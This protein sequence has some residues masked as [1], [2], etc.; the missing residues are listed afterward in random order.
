MGTIEQAEQGLRD[1]A[2]NNARRDALIST[3]RQAGVSK[4]RIHI[5]TGIAR[6]TIDRI[7][8]APMTAT[9]SYG[10]FI[11]HCA[12]SGASANIDSYVATALGEYASDYDVEA[13]VNGFRDGINAEL[14]DTGVSL[15]GDEFY[16]PYPKRDTDIAAAIERVDFW[17]IAAKHDKSA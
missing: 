4:N 6:T 10:S 2:A 7:L 12:D 3:A 8:E 9:T 15:H 5:L 1:W 11:N 17:E 14:D 16:G 13:V